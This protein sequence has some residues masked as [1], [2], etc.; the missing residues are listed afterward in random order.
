MTRGPY[1]Y[2][3]G[4]LGRVNPTIGAPFADYI[5]LRR[6]ELPI[7]T[8]PRPATVISKPANQSLFR[9]QARSFEAVPTPR[10]KS[11]ADFMFDLHPEEKLSQKVANNLNL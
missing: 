8:N 7:R 2:S 5:T 1:R 10:V 6:D 9:I 11:L 3:I 4:G